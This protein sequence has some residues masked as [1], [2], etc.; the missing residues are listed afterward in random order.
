M[1]TL[2]LPFSLIGLIMAFW[3]LPRVREER[4]SIW[5]WLIGLFL[6]WPLFVLIAGWRFDEPNFQIAG[7][8]GIVILVFTILMF[9]GKSF[10]NFGI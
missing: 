8:I 3:I 10:L 4:Y 6:I 7:S 5:P 1:V 9:S 2:L